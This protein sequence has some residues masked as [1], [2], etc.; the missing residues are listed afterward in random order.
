[1][2]YI[3]LMDTSVRS[4]NLGDS[5]IMESVEKGLSP[6]LKGNF[7]V[8]MPTHS[9]VFHKY[10]FSIHKNDGL[11]KGL[12]KFDYKFICGTNLLEKNMKK[13]QN[14]WDY[15]LLDTKYFNNFILVGV[16]TDSLNKI[17]NDYTKKFYDHALS[18]KYIHSTR[19]KKTKDLL[20]ELGFKAVDTGCAT[21]WPL[22]KDWC[23]RIPTS[24]AST[25]IFTLTD[26]KKNFEKDRNLVKILLENYR[27]VYFWPQ[28]IGD[29]DYLN[30]LITDS[31][32]LEKISIINPSLN[33]YDN[34]L[35]SNNCDFVG[36]RLHAGIKAMQ[37]GRR[38]IIIGVDNR[39]ADMHE[40]HHLNFISRENI[41]DLDKMINSDIITKIKLDNNAI[42]MFL[43]QFK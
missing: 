11:S 1:M 6:I 4:F 18:H 29:W 3:A 40:E 23:A 38:A 43:D 8:K 24:K 27:K 33:S 32:I 9:P 21:L 35:K 10:E 30:L 26:Y 19:D 31:Q 2:K 12:R 36:T 13:R 25:V 15:H 41:Q 39:A 7:V 16:G 17:Q 20:E 22:T 37:R 42:N 28:G 14:T 5:I 34:F